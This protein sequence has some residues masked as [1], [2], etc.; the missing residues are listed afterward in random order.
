MAPELLLPEDYGF[1][2]G[3]P[4]KASDIYAMGMVI[5]EVLFFYFFLHQ[6]KIS[7]GDDGDNPIQPIR[8][9]CGDT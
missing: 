7:S 3:N 9:R 5:Y 1:R 2:Q 8:K 6:L 4:S